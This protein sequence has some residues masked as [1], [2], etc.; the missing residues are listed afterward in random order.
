M[1]PALPLMFTGAFLLLSSL[2]NTLRLSLIR[3]RFFLLF[4]TTTP[5]TATLNNFQT[6]TTV[7]LPNGK[8]ST[9]STAVLCLACDESTKGNVADAKHWM[10]A[11][12]ALKEA[13]GN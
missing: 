8:W 13:M 1:V 10:A 5:M 11:Y 2:V 7:T 3:N 12:Y 6:L 9:I 4:F